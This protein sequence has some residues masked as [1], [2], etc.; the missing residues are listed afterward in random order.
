MLLDDFWAFLDRSA[1]AT[2]TK[3]ERTNWLTFRLAK[4]A[5]PQII[6]FELHLAAQRKRVDTWLM[7]GAATHIM[8][9]WCSDD[10]FWYF[11][12]WL[13]GLGRETFDR[14]A[15]DPD[16]LADVPQV[17]ALAARRDSKWSDDEWPEWESLNY[18]AANAY[19]IVMDDTEAFDNAL[20]ERGLS[21]VCDA[22]PED[23]RWNYH[24]RDEFRARFPR[25][26]ALL[27]S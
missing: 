4:V 7:W 16:E 15:A 9:G 3:E 10:S 8:K 13:V 1:A 22:F 21:R 26:A 19:G 5:L 23:R 27:L 6:D 2:R 12:P 24:D 17:R 25:L 11:Q 18:V 20:E 14:V